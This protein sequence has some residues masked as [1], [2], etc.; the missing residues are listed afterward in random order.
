MH[1]LHEK[2]QLSYTIGIVRTKDKWYIDR[3]NIVAK[4]FYPAPDAE[5]EFRYK[6]SVFCNEE[7]GIKHTCHKAKVTT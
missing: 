2:G 1:T 5:N 3:L 6:I 4:D 7:K